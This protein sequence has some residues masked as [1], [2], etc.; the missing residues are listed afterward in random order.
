MTTNIVVNG[1]AGRMGRALIQACTE[2]SDTALAAA[3]VRSTSEY[4]GQDAG[5][6]AGI[7]PANVILNNDLSAL[8]TDIHAWI[9]F[10]LPDG[11]MSAIDHCVENNIPMVIG[12]TGLSEQQKDVISQAGQSIPVVFAPNMSVGVNLC[13]S[14]LQT[15]ART[16]GDEYDIEIVE[17]HH[18]NKVDAPSGTALRMGE[19]I[20]DT[21]N[22][23][24]E[25]N[26][27]YSRHGNIGP[28]KPGTIGFQTI[29]A[30]DIVG[31]HTVTF[32]GIGERVEI[33]HRASSRLTFARGAVRAAIWIKDQPA[34]VYDMQDV[35]G[36]S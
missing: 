33:A 5:V 34:A 3:L 18:K 12:T 25:K 7:S 27:E 8:P 30:G 20:A 23:D 32:A 28:R 36:L 11:L 24:L 17:A 26:A 22:I 29:R 19:V 15:A 21:M 10:T 2:N 35:L 1:A 13:L 4:K 16:L 6:V 9:D 14:I 31:E